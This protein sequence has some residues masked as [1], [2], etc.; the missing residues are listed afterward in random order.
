M[1]VIIQGEQQQAE[2]MQVPAG[3]QAAAGKQGTVL[4]SPDTAATVHHS[5]VAVHTAVAGMA[6]AAEVGEGMPAAAG[7]SLVGVGGR[8]FAGAVVG[9]KGVD[10]A[11]GVEAGGRSLHG[12][13][14][15]SG[16]LL[17]TYACVVKVAGDTVA[18]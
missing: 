13:G 17:V 3:M 4:A 10:D 16:T 11:Q 18:S 5:E 8:M 12:R 1:V 9:S 15:A 7:G 2:G 14:V 6:A